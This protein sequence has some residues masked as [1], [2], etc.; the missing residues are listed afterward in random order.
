MRHN[1]G[2]Q[3]GVDNINKSYESR[4][5]IGNTNNF[6]AN[7]N[8]VTNRNEFDRNNNRLWVP[9]N[10]PANIPSQELMG[11]SQSVHLSRTM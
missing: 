11:K 4:P 10:M 9:S 3:F 1:M 7:I 2:Q 5:N 8:A 6:N